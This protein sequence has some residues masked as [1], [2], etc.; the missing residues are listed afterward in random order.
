MTASRVSTCAVTRSRST[1]PS[2]I[3]D[4]AVLAGTLDAGTWMPGLSQRQSAPDAPHQASRRSIFRA[5][6][7]GAWTY[8]FLVVDANGQAGYQASADCVIDR[9]AGSA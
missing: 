3:V 2:P 9:P 1:L 8:T 6:D 7:S 5:H 4:A